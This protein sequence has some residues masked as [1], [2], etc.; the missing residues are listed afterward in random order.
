MILIDGLYAFLA[1][2]L[3]LLLI[4]LLLLLC[5]INHCL[6]DALYDSL[7]TVFYHLVDTLVGCRAFSGETWLDDRRPVSRE[8]YA[9]FPTPL[10]DLDQLSFHEYALLDCCA[11]LIG[12]HDVSS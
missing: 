3:I 8:Q 11:F 12:A 9:S 4:E 6:L 2:S 1:F 5:L 7:I 10:T